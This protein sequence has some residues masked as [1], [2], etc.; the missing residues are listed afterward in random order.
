MILGG[1]EDQNVRGSEG[2]IRNFAVVDGVESTSGRWRTNVEAKEAISI[3][4]MGEKECTLR[5]D[6]DPGESVCRDKCVDKR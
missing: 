6:S 3:D 2:S 4:A 5:E 1:F